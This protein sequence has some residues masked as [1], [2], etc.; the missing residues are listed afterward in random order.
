LNTPSHPRPTPKAGFPVPGWF[1]LALLI[2]SLACPA[3]A[4]PS[5][6]SA[7]T[8]ADPDAVAL[9]QNLL[10]QRP[11][12]ELFLAGIFKI[13]HSGGR[14][15]EVPVKYALRLAQ[16]HW[17][18]VYQ[19]APTPSFG[20]E[21]LIVIHRPDQPNG[22]SFTQISLD[23]LK[24]NSMS[25]TGAEANVSFADSDFWLTDLG[26]EFLHWPEQRLVRNA[27]ITMRL[28]RPCKVLESTNPTPAESTYGRVV[29]WIDSELGNLIYAEAYDFQNKRFKVFSLKGFKKVN[30]HWQVKE[31]ELRNDKAD[32][33]TRLEFSF[34]AE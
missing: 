14:R 27:K 22:Y 23:G 20:P 13:S 10:S 1:F 32:S 7:S 18:S 31:M 17:E 30:G 6:A 15:S 16:D 21:Q 25:L 28:G 3:A 8:P 29:S 12:K 2:P 11:T 4:P 34:E 19:T 24:T 33:R 26:M 9:V 5:K